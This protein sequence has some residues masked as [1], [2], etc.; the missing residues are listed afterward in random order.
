MKDGGYTFVEPKRM[1]EGGSSD[2]P[3]QGAA[4]GIYPKPK[5]GKALREAGED[6]G[7]FLNALGKLTK[8]QGNKEVESLNKPRATM[9][10][11]NRGI[12][13]PALG[14]TADM[15]NTALTPLDYLGSKLTGRDIKVSSDK[16]FLGSEYIKDLMDKYNVTSGEDRPMM[17]TA[18]SL[19]SPTG[20]IKGAL[21]TANLAKKAPEA[22]NTVRGGLETVSANAQRPFRPATLT[23]EAVAPDL[24]QKGG[25]KFKDLVTKRMITDEGSP[26]NMGTLGGQKTEQTPGQGLYENFAGQLETNP[27]V[28]I[29]IPR[30]GNLST[31]KRLI[32]DIGTAGQ[33]LGQEMVAAHKF[34][35]LLFK[36]PKDATAMM[37]GG[38]EPLTKNQILNISNMLPGMIVTHS[39]KNNAMFV[40][41]FEGDAL[42]Y[43]KAAQAANEILGKGAKVQF[44]KADSTK[45]IMFRGDYKDM[46]ARPPSAESTEMRN[47][48]KKAEERIVRGPSVSQPQRQSPPATLTST[49]R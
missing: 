37:I 1:G 22:I 28:G 6:A 10:I 47:R 38:S 31:N 43:R 40:A 27:M 8:D 41:P 24:G 2:E 19:F 36:N 29:T 35:P 3:K 49:V 15:A 9:D 23:M 7:D 21:K 14:L 20:M 18:L 33:E 26:V 4:F 16:P 44:G 39:P 32:A 48:L 17:E 42:D 11:A 13:A 12:L 30:A 5:G 34:T 46:G 25:D 45:D